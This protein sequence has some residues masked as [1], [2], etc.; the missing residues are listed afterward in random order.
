MA[1]F[2]QFLCLMLFAFVTSSCHGTEKKKSNTGVFTETRTDSIV[3]GAQKYRDYLPLIKNKKVAV[4]ANQTSLTDGMHLVDKLVSEKVNVLRVFAPEHGFRGEAGPGDKV[5]SGKDPVTGLPVVSLYGSRRKPEPSDLKDLDIVIFDIQDVGARFY[6]YISSLHYLMEACA[7]N[8]VEVLIF[9][10]PNPNGFYID[11]PILDTAY[12]S[13]VGIAPLPVV[14][15]L[16]VG[17]YAMMANG[18]GWLTNGIKCQLTVIK[19]DNYAHHKLYELPVRPSPNLPNMN[20]IYLYPSLCFFEGAQVSVGRGTGKPFEMIGFPGFKKGEVT[21]TPKEIPGVIKDPP[22]EGKECAGYDLGSES[23]FILTEKKINLEWLIEMYQA[24]PDQE[25]FFNNFFDKLAGT[26]VLRKQI[27]KGMSAEAIRKSWQPD[28]EKYK[29][30]R[31]KYL[32]YP[33]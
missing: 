31:K 13:F 24:F 29:V 4:M 33:D 20:S 10:R 28:L 8:N 12:R 15:G 26:D 7:E 19:M 32:L 17:E 11:G 2:R 1:Q 30:M 18:E 25:K 9:D 14:H 5:S 3:V 21:F 6:T 22:Y 27:L 23:K 16:T